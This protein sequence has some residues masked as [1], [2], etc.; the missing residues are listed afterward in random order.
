MPVISMLEVQIAPDKLDQ[1]KDILRRVLAETRAFDGCLGV[2]VVQDPADPGRLTAVE[3]WAS[4]E[5]DTA[6]RQWRAGD[7]AITD[8]PEVLAAAPRLSIGVTVEDV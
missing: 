1:A 6:Y 7:G 4:L 3:Q 2:T 5:Q 8:L